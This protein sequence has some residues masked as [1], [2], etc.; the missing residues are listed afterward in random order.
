MSQASKLYEEY[1]V[2]TNMDDIKEMFLDT[3]P[4]LLAVTIVVS[5]LHSVFEFLALKNDISF[6]KNLESHRGLSLRSLYVNLYVEFV[7]LLYLFDNDT[8]T[9]ILVSSIAEIGVTIWKILRTTKFKRRADGQFPWFEIDHKDTYKTTTEAHDQRAMKYLMY[10]L[11]PLYI[12]YIIYSLI[13]EEHKGWYSFFLQ[14]QVG[15]IYVFGFIQM[16]PQLYINYKLKSV[17]H[18]PWRTLIYKFLNTIVDDLFA[19]VITMPW[20]KRLSCFRDDIIFLIYLYQ[21]RI[22]RIDK[23]R[24]ARGN[25][26]TRD[27]V[28]AGNTVPAQNVDTAPAQNVEATGDIKQ[29]TD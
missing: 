17:E 28:P 19:F 23:T 16:T 27:L 24:D 4:Y 22:Y 18:L 15:F 1:G 26:V 7:V 5:L 20:L 13:Y 9:L 8:S 11:M 6:W 14:T 2:D 25:V 12:A 10:V 29:K 21:R 3:N